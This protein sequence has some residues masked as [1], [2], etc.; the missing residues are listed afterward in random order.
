M[1]KLISLLLLAV[2]AISLVGCVA[3]TPTT[4]T[5]TPDTAPSSTPSTL[6]S[7]STPT[8]TTTGIDMKVFA[9]KG[10]TGMGMAKLIADSKT[11]TTF[12]NY[13][14]TIAEN[15]NECLSQ[16]IGGEFDIAAVPTNFAAS[17]L[18]NKAA[19]TYSVI[20]V[21]TLGV[22]YILDT[23]GSVKNVSDLKGK[24]IYATGEGTVPQFVLE[25]ILKKAGFEIGKDVN[26]EYL[27]TAADVGAMLE[28]GTAKVA[29]LPQPYV[30]TLQ[31][32]AK[33]VNVALDLTALW[34]ELSK[35]ESRLMT[36]CVVVKNELVKNNRGAVEKFLQE[37]AASVSYVNSGSDEAAQS[38][39]DAGIV[40][41]LPVA[42]KA[43]PKCNIVFITGEEMVKDLGGFYA[44]LYSI[45]PQSVGG[46]IPTEELYVK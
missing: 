38:V 27:A 28:A 23:D 32:K 21:N 37:Y 16:L 31:N 7:T 35:G 34:D 11:G 46:K 4:S 30:T 42:K 6:E 24:T 8:T 18:S 17:V 1:K 25:Y 2:M 39:V 26:V 14:F 33:N 12:N 5:L 44:A 40:G 9:M 43:I 41:A 45:N 10:P 36:G 22:L 29:M 13:N 3:T 19:G 20:A 15:V